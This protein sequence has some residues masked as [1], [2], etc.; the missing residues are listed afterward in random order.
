M[1]AQPPG[2]LNP[3]HRLGWPEG[4]PLGHNQ[5]CNPLPEALLQEVQALGA[6]LPASWPLAAYEQV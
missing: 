2:S 3:P 5:T 6:W 1:A 4:D